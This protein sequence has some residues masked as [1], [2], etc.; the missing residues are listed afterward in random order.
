[1]GWYQG[2]KT[3]NTCSP[4]VARENVIMTNII[5]LYENSQFFLTPLSF[6]ARSRGETLQI[7][8]RSSLNI[9]KAE[10]TL[11]PQLSEATMCASNL[12]RNFTVPT[13]GRRT[14]RQTDGLRQTDVPMICLYS[15]LFTSYYAYAL[16]KAARQNYTP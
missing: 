6:N 15:G 7:S 5:G 14:E 8:T 2:S 10:F 9:L 1:M 16:Y 3:E 11:K 4:T 12:G 13:R